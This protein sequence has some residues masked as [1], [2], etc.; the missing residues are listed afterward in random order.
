ME[1]FKEYKSN[2]LGPIRW[3][4]HNEHFFLSPHLKRLSEP[5]RKSLLVILRK[6]P[7]KVLAELSV[8]YANKEQVYIV[9]I[10]KYPRLLQKIKQ[11]F[12]CTKALKEFRMTCLAAQKGVPVEIPVA[13]GERKLFF[14]KE[15]YLV[16]RKINFCS[17]AGEY[18]KGAVSHNERGSV[19]EKFGKLA[20]IMHN[21]GVR[22]NDFSL[23][24]FLVFPDETGDNKIILIDFERVSIQAKGLSEKNC[25]WYLAKLNR[26]TKHFTRT[27]RLKFLLSYTGYE[28]DYCKKLAKHINRSTISIQKKDAEKFRKQCVQENRKFGMYKNR[29]YTGFYRKM[30]SSDTLETLLRMA[31]TAGRKRRVFYKDQFRIISFKQQGKYS[32]NAFTD[33][34]GVDKGWM[35]KCLKKLKP[36]SCGV[37][38]SYCSGSSHYAFIRVWKHANALFALRLNVP[39]PVGIFWAALPGSGKEWLLISKIPENSIS[40]CRWREL[41]SV[42]NLRY[43]FFRLAEQI[44]PYGVFRKDLNVKDIL[45]QRNG[46]RLLKCYLKDYTSFQVNSCP[47]KQN[48]SFNM[49]IVKQLLPELKG[50]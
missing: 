42:E 48:R 49:R 36:L 37:F 43:A 12:K 3:S 18:F 30:Y 38:G 34:F 20:S 8:T 31:A 10:Y 47:V 21:A 45:V 40:F 22:Q 13:F 41:Q 28:I 39:F 24:N 9:K 33:L 7:Y 4:I 46:V 26:E 14:V 32:F 27:E 1:K 6:N 5:G 44:S 11:F 25:I 35:V 17:T 15:S 19:L 2:I 50:Y 16:I 23:N 29:K